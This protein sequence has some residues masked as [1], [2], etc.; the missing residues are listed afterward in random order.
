MYLQLEETVRQQIEQIA[1]LE[2]KRREGEMVRRR[3][4]N[5]IQDLKG[6]IR[7]YCRVRPALRRM[8]AFVRATTKKLS[9]V[10]QCVDG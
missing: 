6:N 7:V 4:H 9:H 5:H 8:C 10:D 2:S 3:L 1:T